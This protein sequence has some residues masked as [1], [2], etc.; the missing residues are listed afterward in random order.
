VT[1]GPVGALAVPLNRRQVEDFAVEGQLGRG[2][3][4]DVLGPELRLGGEVALDR[5]VEGQHLG[6]PQGE[7]LGADLRFELGPE[8]MVEQRP[9]HPD[10]ELGPAGFGLVPLLPLT[11]AIGVGRVLLEPQ[12]HERAVGRHLPADGVPGPDRGQAQVSRVGAGDG[13]LQFVDR[14]GQGLEVGCRGGDVAEALG[15]G[16]HALHSSEVSMARTASSVTDACLA[17]PVGP[18]G[19]AAPAACRAVTAA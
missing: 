19:P 8:G 7:G 2:Q 16:S 11:L 17:G 15:G 6:L 5:R 14:D 9:L 12:P 10:L 18:A 1:H 13:G 4:L 3:Q